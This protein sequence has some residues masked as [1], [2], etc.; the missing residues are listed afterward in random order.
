MGRQLGPFGSGF[1]WPLALCRLADILN[2]RKVA[3]SPGGEFPGDKIVLRNKERLEAGFRVNH[4]L[5]PPFPC[6]VKIDAGDIGKNQAARV[7]SET[8]EAATLCQ[9]FRANVLERCAK[10]GER[11]I[12]RLR[13]RGVGLYEKVKVLRKA[14]LRVK[15][16]S[17]SPQSGI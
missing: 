11:V 1:L 17:I 8:K 2:I 4:A 15:D 14:G 7:M 3:D 13:A 12:C 5:N 10:L 16:N 6:G 9:V